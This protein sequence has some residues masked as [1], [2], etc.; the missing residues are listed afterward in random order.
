MLAGVAYGAGLQEQSKMGNLVSRWLVAFIAM[1]AAHLA[2]AQDAWPTKPVVI[3][4]PFAAGGVADLL[5]RVVGAKLSQKWHQPVIVENKVG[6]SGNIGMAQGAHAAPDG[7]TW[8]LAPAG[9]LTVNPILFK[10]LTFDTYK[11][12]TPVTNLA[13]SPNLLVVH[14]SVPAKT[15]K[16]LIAY[17]K[18][19]PGKLNF[20]S[21]GAGSGAHLAGELL[22]VD[23]GIDMVHVPYKGL[24]P[25]VNDLLAGHTQLMFAG[26]STV[27]QYVKTGQLVAIAIASP[28]RSPELPDVPTVDESGLPHFEVISWY[29]IVTRTGTPPAII[30][31][32]QHDM[33]EALAQDDV[34]AKLANVGLE[35]VGSTPEEFAATIKRESKKWGDIVRKAN[36]TVE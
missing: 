2:F 31:K 35:P 23:A 9:N 11:D 12:L 32:M 36:I 19:N 1:L 15:L 24:A 16:E 27:I 22:K 5:P 26:I 17:A 14:P 20:A 3:I 29:G 28:R 10:H 30:A 13:Q 8:V 6:A 34:R 18:A 4:V 7:Y 21:P 33:A 25:A